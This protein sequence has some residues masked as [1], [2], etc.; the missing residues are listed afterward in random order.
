MARRRFAR[1]ALYMRLVRLC[2]ARGC[3]WDD[4]MELVQVQEA[5]L[6]LFGYS[7][8]ATVRDADS[9]LRRIVINLSISHY[10]R[11]QAQP[12]FHS[13]GRLELIDPAPDPE[14]IVAAEQ[15]LDDV[16]NLLSAGSMRTAQ[17]FIAHRGGYSYEEIAAA[18]F[19]KERPVK[20]R[21][22][23]AGNKWLYLGT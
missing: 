20:Y 13:L 9:L 16:A 4:A 11:Q 1:P 22:F 17:I 2:R 5:H 7:K 14:R 18:F 21:S 8:T 19:V 12:A 15:Q 6:R 23:M 10:H 3:S